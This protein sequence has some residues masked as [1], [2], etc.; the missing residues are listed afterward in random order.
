[1]FMKRF[2]IYD[3]D[4]IFGIISQRRYEFKHKRSKTEHVK[5]IYINDDGTKEYHWL[6]LKMYFMFDDTDWEITGIHRRKIEYYPTYQ[7]DDFSELIWCNPNRLSKLIEKGNLITMNA[8]I[9]Y[10]FTDEYR[11]EIE[12][13]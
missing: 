3:L 13:G 2:K 11:E 4:S 5:F 12:N 10:E 7:K 1:M 8:D 9:P 6:K